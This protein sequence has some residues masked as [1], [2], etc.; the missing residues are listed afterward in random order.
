M[1]E[2]GESTCPSCKQAVGRVAVKVPQFGNPGPGLALCPCCG[3]IL[4]VFWVGELS[5][6][7]VKLWTK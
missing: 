4:G 5:A 3:A 2:I 1:G 6:E 7:T